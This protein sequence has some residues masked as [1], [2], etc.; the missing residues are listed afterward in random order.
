M[1]ALLYLPAI[2]AI[3][4]TAGAALGGMA[5]LAGKALLDM[6]RQDRRQRRT[7]PAA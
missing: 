4:F 5:T 1:I 3:H 7:P 6:R 2:A